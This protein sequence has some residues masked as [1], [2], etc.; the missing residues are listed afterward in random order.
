MTN[1]RPAWREPMVWLIVGLPVSAIAA[2]LALVVQ[3]LH[4]GPDD[5]VI[6]DVQ[7]VAQMP[8]R[9]PRADLQASRLGLSVTLLATERDLQIVPVSGNFDRGM[10]LKLTLAHPADDDH[11]VHVILKPVAQGWSALPI[12]V[13]ANDWI[14]RIESADGSWRLQGRLRRGERALLLR[15]AIL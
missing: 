9:D 11:D 3:A 15:A 7:H 8:L 13:D 5:A 6:D 10:P 14:V 12:A 1:T 2:S 4:A